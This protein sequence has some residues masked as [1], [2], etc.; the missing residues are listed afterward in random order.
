MKLIICSDTHLGRKNFKVNERE[1]DFFES[2][3]QVIDHSINNEAKAVL[4]AGDLFDT[5]KPNINVIIFAV[6]QLKRLKSKNI[7]FFIVSGSHDI[8]NYDSFLNVLDAIGLCTNLTSKRYY[9]LNDE[10]LLLKGEK[11]NELFVSGIPGKNNIINELECLKPII[12]KDCFSIFMFH[13]IIEDISPLFSSLK[14]S[15]LPKGFDLYVSGHWH[16]KFITTYGK[17]QLIYPGSTENCDLN[18]MKSEKKGFFEYE[19]ISKKFEF[20]ELKTRKSIIHE[21]DCTGLNPEEITDKMEELIKPANQEMIFFMLKGKMK[22]GLKSEINRQRITELAM[23]NNYLLSKIYLN[24]LEDA[25]SEQIIMGK[26]SINEI[27]SE[28]LISK[29]FSKDE[30]LAAI[31]IMK[32]IS[33]NENNSIGLLI[34]ELKNE[35]F[36]K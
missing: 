35:A 2:F 19:T 26:K 4:H 32:I 12:P 29:G 14:K 24:Q 13:H 7:P 20:I 18:E 6:E 9:E 30:T 33:S 36:L 25:F 27:E 1:N 31:K 21:I 22:K 23:K 15:M 11:F 34:N 3:K 8:G 10:N 17:A 16:E 28:F 5:S